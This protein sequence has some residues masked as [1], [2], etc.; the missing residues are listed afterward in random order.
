MLP[1]KSNSALRTTRHEF[2]TD[3]LKWIPSLASDPRELEAAPQRKVDP[4]LPGH[5]VTFVDST[6]KI[7][8]H[9]R[10][11]EVNTRHDEVAK[12]GHDVNLLAAFAIKKYWEDVRAEILMLAGSDETVPLSEVLRII[13]EPLTEIVRMF[14]TLSKATKGT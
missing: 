12:T 8:P 7:R 6:P 10:A 4:A 13:D 11:A 3:Y 2:G 9:F 14:N 1:R 5:I